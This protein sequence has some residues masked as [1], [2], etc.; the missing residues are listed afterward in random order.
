VCDFPMKLDLLRRKSE[1]GAEILA[2]AQGCVYCVVGYRDPQ[3]AL[4]ILSEAYAASDDNVGSCEL[5]S[6]ACIDMVLRHIPGT[7]DP[8]KAET[9]W[10][11]LLEWSSSRPRQ[12]GGAGMSEKMERFLADQLEAGREGTIRLVSVGLR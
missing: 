9:E 10:Y 11:L 12:D 3:A 6:S 5:M 8:L 4:D 7:Q 2:G 1:C